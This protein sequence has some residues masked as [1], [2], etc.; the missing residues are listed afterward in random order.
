M[1]IRPDLLEA[2]KD[3]DEGG[4]GIA[5]KFWEWTEEQIKPYL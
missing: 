1:K 2:S 5:K 3:V 4:T